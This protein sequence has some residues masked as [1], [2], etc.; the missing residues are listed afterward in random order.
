[1]VKGWIGGDV[2]VE[3]VMVGVLSRRDESSEHNRAH[4]KQQLWARVKDNHTI[5]SK[6]REPGSNKDTRRHQRIYLPWP[7]L[8]NSETNAI[9]REKTNN[10]LNEQINERRECESM[11]NV[12]KPRTRD[13]ATLQVSLT[14]QP[15]SVACKSYGNAVLNK[16]QNMKN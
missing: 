2:G 15:E 9:S 4:L 16:L 10:L 5:H 14:A 12:W 1:L 3:C 13:G 7:L 11:V 6:Y 8:L